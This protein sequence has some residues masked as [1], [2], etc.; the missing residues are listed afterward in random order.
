VT[1][2]ELQETFVRLQ[3]EWVLWALSLPGVKLRDGE[4][5]ILQ[6][7]PDNKGRKAKVF[8]TKQSVR[9]TDW[10]H[11]DGG[12]HYNGV[13]KD[14]VLFVDGQHITD[15]DHPMWIKLGEK[16]ESMHPAARWGGRF[17]DANHTSMEW[18][19]KK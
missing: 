8:G 13:G 14:W 16:W 19:G 4:G 6:S 7:G 3:A 9:V 10:V 12:T 2:G 5:R 17:M 18:N 11:L 1:L 15:G